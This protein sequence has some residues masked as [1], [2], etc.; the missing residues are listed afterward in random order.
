MKPC[1]AKRKPLAWLALGDLDERQAQALRAHVQTCEGCRQ[2]LEEISALREG[3][4]AADRSPSL[5]PS[6]WFHRKW[7]GRLKAEESASRWHLLTERL[8]WRVA[9]PALGA[10][11]ALVILTLSLLPRQPAVSVPVRMSHA[12]VTAP[13]AGRDLSPSVANYQRVAVRS[14]DEFD[15]LLTAQANRKPSPAPTYTASIFAAATSQN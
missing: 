4:A 7:V 10:A 6:D 12:E 14:L 2:Y 11:A 5:E 8:S 9:V 13:A 1:F 3:L 15:D